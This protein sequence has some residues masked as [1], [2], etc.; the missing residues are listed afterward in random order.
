MLKYTQSEKV[1]S[2]K[3]LDVKKERGHSFKSYRRVKQNG[4]VFFQCLHKKER[5]V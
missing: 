3:I 1:R 4:A 2:T 5:A